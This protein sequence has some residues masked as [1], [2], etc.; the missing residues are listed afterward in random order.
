MKHGDISNHV[1]SLNIGVRLNGFLVD[2]KRMNF[3]RRAWSKLGGRLNHKAI[4]PVVAHFV[5]NLFYRTSFTVD[6]VYV[7]EIELEI[8]MKYTDVVQDV[9]RNRVHL[10]EDHYGVERLLYCGVLS[11]F[12]T[13]PTDV[14]LMSGEHAYTIERFN[15]MLKKSLNLRT[16]Q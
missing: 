5:E 12:V 14:E 3:A 10:V 9:P 11:Y 1:S 7:G 2:P 13:A 8:M 15:S 6:L 4:D 16:V